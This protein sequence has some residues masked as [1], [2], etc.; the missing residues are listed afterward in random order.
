MEMRHWPELQQAHDDQTWTFDFAAYPKIV[1][2]IRGSEVLDLAPQWVLK[3]WEQVAKL[4]D[5]VSPAQLQFN[6]LLRKKYLCPVRN[7]ILGT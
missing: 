4:L 7:R 2:R 3:A 1:Q 6:A 5:D